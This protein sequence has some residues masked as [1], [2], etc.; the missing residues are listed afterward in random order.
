MFTLGAYPHPAPAETVQSV[1]R[2]PVVSHFLLS[3]A[4]ACDSLQKLQVI[5]KDAK[6]QEKKGDSSENTLA[7]YYKCQQKKTCNA[8]QKQKG[9]EDRADDSDRPGCLL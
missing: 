1:F 9:N 4:F 2:S 8:E 3:L 7:L 5:G 6:S